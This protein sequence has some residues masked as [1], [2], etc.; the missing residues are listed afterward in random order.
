MLQIRVGF[1]VLFFVPGSVMDI[2]DHISEYFGLKKILKF[3]ETGPNTGFGIFLTRDPGWK[4]SD[5]NE[6]PESATLSIID[7]FTICE[8]DHAKVSGLCHILKTLF[9]PGLPFPFFR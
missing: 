2:L 7:P 3:F 8:P 4:N 6:H 9:Q 5:Q 1:P